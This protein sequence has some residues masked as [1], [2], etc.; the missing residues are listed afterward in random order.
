MEVKLPDSFF[1]ELSEDEAEV[2]R[3]WAMDNYEPGDSISP[4]WHPVVRRECERINRRSLSL[5]GRD[6]TGGDGEDSDGGNPR[7]EAPNEKV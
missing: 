2:Y 6:K 7:A 4:M 5:S 1:R 3:I